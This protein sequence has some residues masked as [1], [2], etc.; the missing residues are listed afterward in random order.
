[1]DEAGKTAQI[2]AKMKYYN[3]TL[4]GIREAR[5]IQ[6][7]QCRLLQGNYSSILD[8]N[9]KTLHTHGVALMLSKTARD[10]MIGWE[11]HESGII[12]ASFKTKHKRINTNIIQCY[13]PTNDAE[14]TKNEF[15][16][17]LQSVVRKEM[18]PS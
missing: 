5:W 18:L 17:R 8:M 4:L 1:M 2:V 13:A 16:K 15:F 6:S 12:K 10:A 7:G 14:E 3:L 11:A 9:K